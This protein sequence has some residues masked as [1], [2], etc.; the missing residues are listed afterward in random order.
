M[1]YLRGL[2]GESLAAAVEYINRA[3][4]TT[5]T[6]LRRALAVDPWWQSMS[7]QADT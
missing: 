1:Q 4:A 6:P 3:P 7:A 5:D 2:E